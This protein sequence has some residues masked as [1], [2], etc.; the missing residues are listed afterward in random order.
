LKLR[1]V[2]VLVAIALL[3]AGCS[4]SFN[5]NTSSSVSPSSSATTRPGEIAVTITYP[6]NYVPAMNVYA[7]R[8]DKSQSP[9]VLQTNQSNTIVMAVFRDVPP[10][11]YHVLAYNPDPALANVRGG[12]TRAVLCGGTAGCI[13]HTMVDVVVAPGAQV[14]VIIG[15]YF[16]ES[17]PLQPPQ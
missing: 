7:V 14:K 5:I 9:L 17:I 3:L 10:G 4:M 15:D 8:V 2:C 13:D 6:G 16:A 11:T 1:T 12:Y